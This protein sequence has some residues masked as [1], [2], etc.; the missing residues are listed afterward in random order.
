MK[1]MFSNQSLRRILCFQH[2]EPPPHTHLSLD[3]R[4]YVNAT[5]PQ[6]WINSGGP[7]CGSAHLTNIS[8]VFWVICKPRFMRPWLIREENLVSRMSVAAGDVQKCSKCHA[9][10]MLSLY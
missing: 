4:Q 3:I 10:P 7:F 2:D 8:S 5:L 6:Y 1:H 9:E